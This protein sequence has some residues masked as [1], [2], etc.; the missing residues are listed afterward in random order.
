MLGFGGPFVQLVLQGAILVYTTVI[1][2]WLRPYHDPWKNAGYLWIMAMTMFSTV[3]Q[4][5]YL[6]GLEAESVPFTYLVLVQLVL[7]AVVVVLFAL[8]GLGVR[9][10]YRML[11]GWRKG[12]DRIDAHLYAEEQRQ[13]LHG[14]DGGDGASRS[15]SAA[16]QDQ[17]NAAAAAEEAQLAQLAR[18]ELLRLTSSGPASL[19]P[20]HALRVL[21]SVSSVSRARVY[22]EQ[23][24]SRTSSRYAADYLT[25]VPRGAKTEGRQ[26][27]QDETVVDTPHHEVHRQSVISSTIEFSTVDSARN[28]D[29]SSGGSTTARSSRSLLP[30]RDR[31]ETAPR[32]L[33]AVR[34]TKRMSVSHEP[35]LQDDPDEP[36]AD[37]AEGSNGWHP[38][39][40]PEHEPPV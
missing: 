9:K 39:V 7:F 15:R 22:P 18:K 31:H 19:P 6:F 16:G 5:L 21:Q 24:R 35:L 40:V 23:P 3:G 4:L 28:S 27:G 8:W 33:P 17:A 29:D 10:L 14:K 20:S 11:Q 12:I 36:A 25:D 32:E 13:L 34:L 38:G 26:A 1:F 37:H 2:V 30:R